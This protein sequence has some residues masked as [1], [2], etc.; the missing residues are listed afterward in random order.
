LRKQLIQ[1]IKTFNSQLM[2]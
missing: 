1:R 2:L